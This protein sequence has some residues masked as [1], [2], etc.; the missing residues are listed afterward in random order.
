MR[1]EWHAVF[2]RVRDEEGQTKTVKKTFSGTTLMDL[3]TK[4]QNYVSEMR[5]D[6]WEILV[7]LVKDVF[8]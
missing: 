1:V 6:G 2:Y 5:E 7:E 8:I 3:H 4:I